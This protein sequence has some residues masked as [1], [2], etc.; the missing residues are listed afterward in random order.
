M[1]FFDLDG[2]LI[3]SNGVWVQIDL[4]F[5][6]S[7]GFAVTEDYT[8]YVTHHTYEDAALYTKS[9]FDLP[10]SPAQIMQEWSDR[11]E[12]AYAKQVP[13]KDGVQDYLELLARKGVRLAIITSC[14]GHLCRAALDQHR[15]G[16]YFDFILT[17]KE[18]PRDKRFP[19]IYRMAADRAGVLPAQCELFEDSP[20]AVLGAREAGFFVTGVHDDFFASSEAVMRRDCDRYIISFRELLS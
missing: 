14:M 5:L 4:D 16:A 12:E 10:E 1:K 6:G 18:S 8:E 11:A 17:T 7:R 2:T 13:L 3:D 19:D 20:K 15:I 9:R